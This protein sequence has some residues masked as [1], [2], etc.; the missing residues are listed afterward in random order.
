MAQPPAG[1][2][3]VRVWY[4]D[5]GGNGVDYDDSNAVF[6]VTPFAVTVAAPNG[7]EGFTEYSS[8][9]V[10]WGLSVGVVSGSFD[11]WVYSPTTSWYQLN[12]A[13]IAAVAGQTSYSFPW[14]VAQPPAGDYKVR[15][16]YRDAGGNGVD[17][18]D[19]NAVFAINALALTVTAP[20][21]GESFV[22][23][24]VP[25]VTWSVSSAVASGSFDVWVYSPTTSWYK[26]NSAPVAAVAGQANYVFAW[27]VAEPPAADYKM[28]VW[29]VNAA[30][31]TRR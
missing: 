7:G 23:G 12:T 30:G 10:T 4:R 15:V 13:P 16:W 8:A 9:S 21:G 6:A 20:N 24:S 19:S 25:T 2:Y 26:L 1:D 18:D 11:V 28:R 3:K 14:T 29:Y 31:M 22:P 5:A 27:T 17:Y